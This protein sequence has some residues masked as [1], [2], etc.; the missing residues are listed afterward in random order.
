VSTIVASCTPPGCNPASGNVNSN[1]TGAGLAVYSNP[2]KATVTG[3]TV[4]T[5]YVTGSDKPDGTAN[6]SLIPID[7]STNTAGTAVTLPAA[8]NSMVFSRDG[9]KAYIGTANGLAILDPGTNTITATATGL[10][11][12]VLTV[13][14]NGSKV[15]LSDISGGKVFVFDSGANSSQEFDNIANVTAA[16]F[17]A[18]NSKAYFTSGTNVYEYSPGTGLKTLTF[19]ADGVVFT[20]QVSIAYF[21]GSSITGLAICNDSVIPG[22]AV[23]ANVLSVTPDGTH[24][25]AVGAAGWADLSYTVTNSGCPAKATNTLTTA[26]GSFVDT[27]GQIAVAS[28]DSNAFVTGYT[29][30]TIATGVPFYHFADGTTGSIALMGSGGTLFSGG[31]TQDAHSLYVGVG[32]NGSTGP[33]V[34]RIDLTAAGGPADTTPIN[35]PSPFNPRIVVVRPQ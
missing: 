30:T 9:T 34:H 31:I 26:A 12:K 35:L 6:T 21:G 20:P 22:A 27:P 7:I 16:D 10:T 8:P 5:V 24:M 32:A 11:G 17:A 33:Q 28:D 29:G 1:G 13:S 18:D 3:T 4:K 25:I 14:N 23:A 2:F 19:A 15:V